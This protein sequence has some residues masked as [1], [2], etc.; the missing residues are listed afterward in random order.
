M[1]MKRVL[2]CWFCNYKCGINKRREFHAKT[3]PIA[4]MTTTKNKKSSNSKFYAVARGRKT[5]IFRSWQECS[6]Q[7]GLCLLG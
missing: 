1:F 4:P 2:V 5:G 6:E 3:P 7:V